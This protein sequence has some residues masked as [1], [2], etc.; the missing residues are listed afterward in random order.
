MLLLSVVKSPVKIIQWL[1]SQAQH[2]ILLFENV[3]RITISQEL[4]P[5]DCK[6]IDKISPIKFSKIEAKNLLILFWNFLNES[7]AS[8]AI[9]DPFSL[10]KESKGWEESVNLFIDEFQNFESFFH[11]LISCNACYG[12]KAVERES[13]FNEVYVVVN[14]LI[15]VELEF[16]LSKCNGDFDLIAKLIKILSDH[17]PSARIYGTTW[18]M[19]DFRSVLTRMMS[20]CCNDTIRSIIHRYLVPDR[21]YISR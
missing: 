9:I 17:S 18:W 21:V 16:W 2:I 6:A 19:N 20:S 3:V 4:E 15:W 8:I 13:P 7:L 1:L 5:S 12:F 10:P 11:F 14:S